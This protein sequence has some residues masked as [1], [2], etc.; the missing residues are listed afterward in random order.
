MTVRGPTATASVRGTSFEFDTYSITVS[1][2]TVA[3]QGA[4]GAPMMVSAGSSSEVT[5][6]GRAADPIET[7]AAELTLPTVA[8]TDS[9]YQ[10]FSVPDVR[11]GFSF[12]FKMKDDV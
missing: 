10:H 12:K 9:G 2:G 11:G 5:A 6:T 7:D 8:G 1:E 3:F 4:S